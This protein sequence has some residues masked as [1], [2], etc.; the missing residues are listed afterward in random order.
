MSLLHFAS[1]LGLL[2]GRFPLTVPSVTFSINRLS[3]SIY[4]HTYLPE[5]LSGAFSCHGP[6]V[7]S[8]LSFCYICNFCL[9]HLS[10]TE[11]CGIRR[12][13]K[14]TAVIKWC[15]RVSCIVTQNELWSD[16]KF[17]VQALAVCASRSNHDISWPRSLAY[18][19]PSHGTDTTLLFHLFEAGREPSA[20]RHSIPE[21]Y[22]SVF[23]FVVA[24]PSGRPQYHYSSASILVPISLHRAVILCRGNACWPVRAEIFAKLHAGTT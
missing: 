4:S 17:G 19:L 20:D 7:F 21:H 9:A 6:S 5:Q 1:L 22:T 2:G 16:D 3:S 23:V 11:I 15:M 18:D 13:T 10:Q 24:S 14:F 12:S 8:L